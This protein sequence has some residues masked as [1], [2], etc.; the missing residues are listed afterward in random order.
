MSINKTIKN[1]VLIVDDDISSIKELNH[2]LNPE[3]TIHIAK[4]G[5]DCIEAAEKFIPDVILLDIIMP[6]M[7]GYE[8]ITMLKES[9]ITKNIPVIFITGLS[10]PDDEEKGLAL[11][12]ADYIIKPFSP[13][14][15][16]LRVRNQIKILDLLFEAEAANKAKS[17][18]LSTMSHEIRTPMNV[19]VGLTDLML[20]EDGLNL[21]LKENLKKISTAGNTL[22]G[23]INDILD[24]SKIEAGKLE[25][26]PVEYEMASFLNDI[27]TLNM[28]RIEDKPIKFT[29]DIHEDLPCYLMGD[30][31]RVRQIIN[32][33]LSNAFKYTRKGTVT[34]GIQCGKTENEDI[35]MSVY[36]SDTGIGIHKED[37]EKLFT[38]YGQVD[39]RTNRAIE[40]TGLG[41]AITKRLTEMM[42]GEITA[43]S[44][45]G[46]GSTFRFRIRQGF[47]S[48]KVIGE[49][50]AENLRSFSY[51][52]NRKRASEKL[53]RPDLSYASVLVV[54]D[55]QTNLDVA[56]GMLKKY[57]IRVDCVLNG[58]DAIDRISEGEPVYDAIF[59]DHMMIGMDGVETTE[60]IR[61]IGTKYAM[62]IPV[63][64]LTANA[65]A[66]NEQIFLSKNFQAFLAKPI[67][68][69]NLDSIVQ[70]WIR[71]KTREQ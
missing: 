26:A 43:E 69:I 4:S 22:L 70:K 68:I 65:I 2:I 7:D 40:G 19:V 56:A 27:I 37:I 55:M 8:V 51:Q 57:K 14:I 39:T 61:A 50:T 17:N 58:Q 59:M 6:D 45:Y 54:D 33:L 13:A 49:K 52:D 35:L 53:V 44:E 16:K 36:V 23:L 15:V 67:N 66:G 5:K 25:I 10:K 29:L 9:E 63:I 28:I 41:L 21:H 47:V 42:G 1:S 31:L 34:L 38:D 46:K 71:D 11:G 20:D 18:F 3:Y 62:T 32:N 64:A 24:I 12:A 48:D 60:K 30:D